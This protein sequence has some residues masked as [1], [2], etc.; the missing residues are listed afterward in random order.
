M[1]RGGLLP[2]RRFSPSCRSAPTLPQ[3]LRPLPRRGGL[4]RPS[5]ASPA[6]V[7][8]AYAA[9]IRAEAVYVI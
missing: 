2:R 9:A 7:E 5:A 4:A 1:R 6:P 3:P 8:A